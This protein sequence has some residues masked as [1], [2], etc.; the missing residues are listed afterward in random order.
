M[1]EKQDIH[2]IL[3]F[4]LQKAPRIDLTF[5]PT[6]LH[7]LNGV[8]REYDVEIFIKRD[9]LTGSEFGGN[10]TRK[11]EYVLHEALEK[12]AKY[13]V[14]GASVQSN[15]CR[16]VT[17]AAARCGLKTILYLFDTKM[18]QESRGNLLLDKI[19]G[20][21]I[22]CFELKKGETL[23]D[24]LESTSALRKERMDQLEAQGEKCHYIKVGA[25]VP[26]GHVAYISAMAEIID[27]FEN[28]GKNI[29]DID[30][31]V[32]P[33][34]AGGTYAGL[35]MAKNLFRMKSKVLGFCTS[36]MHPTMVEDIHEACNATFDFLGFGIA[37]N[38]EDINVS[39]EYGGE[40]DVPTTLSTGALQKVAQMD[41][42]ILDPVYT[43]KAMSG[44]LDYIQKG[45]ISSGSKILFLHT[46]GVPALFS[47]VRTAGN[48]DV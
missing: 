12:G 28:M 44:L 27:Q 39:F 22:H 33:L 25:P 36:S 5:L 14:T 18:P 26:K 17:S 23:Y 3:S 40:Y 45:K 41:G 15:W 32:T 24:G 38:T 21:E 4:I 46:G 11:L 43:S 6:P 31:I 8:S 1:R 2:R 20:A 16:Q 34:G 7:K 10:K 47:G 48:F 13:I 9:D 30:Y 35:L 19:L 29:D 37:P 42:V